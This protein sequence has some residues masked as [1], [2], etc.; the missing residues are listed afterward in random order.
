MIGVM[1]SPIDILFSILYV[2]FKSDQCGYRDHSIV[3]MGIQ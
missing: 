3:I 1:V 2:K